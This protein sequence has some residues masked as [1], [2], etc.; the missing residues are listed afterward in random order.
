[1]NAPTALHEP[2]T[3]RRVFPGW[4]IEIP[5]A[6]EETFV[7]EGA[8][9]W[10]AYDETR[11]VSLTSIV[12]TEDG[13]PVSAA[14]IVQETRGLAG[15]GEIITQLPAG[16]PGWACRAPADSEARASRLI[17]GGVAVDGVL[18][19]ATVTADNDAWALRTWL[20]IRSHPRGH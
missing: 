17:S 7:V 18:L 20:S 1:M 10:H 6:F 16:R 5:E 2:T 3:R 11:S 4:S 13:R 19:L 15:G 8:G 9:Y 12:L 14:R